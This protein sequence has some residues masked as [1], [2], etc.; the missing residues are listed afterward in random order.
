M[1]EELKPWEIPVGYDGQPS[2]VAKT[3]D[4]ESN[5]DFYARV[6]NPDEIQGDP[7]GEEKGRRD[8]IND[9]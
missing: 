1:A 3:W 6:S 8:D 9:G 7:E 4:E 5:D 2:P